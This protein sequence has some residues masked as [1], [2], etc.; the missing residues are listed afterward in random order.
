MPVARRVTKPAVET[1]TLGKARDAWLAS[2]QPGCLPKTFTIKKTA[3]EALVSFLGKRPNSTG[4]PVR[5][6]SVVSVHARR[7]SHPHPYE[8]AVIGGSG[9]FSNG[10]LSA[11]TQRRQPGR[12]HITHT[13]EAGA[14][15]GGF[16][17]YD[18]HQV[19]ALFAPAASKTWPCP[20]VGPRCWASTRVPI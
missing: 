6:G 11:T 12:G 8:Q 3:I 14:E 7:R 10:W 16:K 1:I 17:A 9:G 15:E 4:H 5:P 13:R 2:I 20:P 19:Q 18:S